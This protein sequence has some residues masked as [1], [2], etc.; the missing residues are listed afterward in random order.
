MN[1]LSQILLS[2]S[3]IMVTVASIFI[4]LSF[5]NNVSGSVSY[6][7]AIENM[8]VYGSENVV[9][10]S[11]LCL[12]LFGLLIWLVWTLTHRTR[13]RRSFSIETKKLVLRKQ[14]FKCLKCKGNAGIWD[15]DHKD[16]NRGNNKTSNCQA[17]CPICHAKKSRGQI[18]CQPQNKSRNITMGVALGIVLIV[19]LYSYNL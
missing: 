18:K 16:G 3:T 19:I 12:I 7:N 17:L 13:R 14:N 8:E 11:L 4:L 9:I 6:R 1:Q 2:P 15:F 10:I 5:S